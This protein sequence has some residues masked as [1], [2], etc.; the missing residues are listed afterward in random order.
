M[1]DALIFDTECYENFWYLGVKRCSDGKRVGYEFSDRADFDRSKVRRMLSRYL[2]VGFNSR[3]Y[4]LPMIYMA[5]DGAS[6]SELKAASNE[7]IGKSIPWWESER[8]FGIHI[9]KIDHIDLFDTNPSVKRGLKEINGSMHL[10]RLQELPY[11]HDTILSPEQMDEV[12]AYCQ[13]G[14]LDGT[15]KLYEIL[16]EPIDLRIAMGERYGDDYRSKSDAQMGEAIIKSEVEKKTNRRVR[17]GDV[18]IGASFRFEPPPWMKFETPQLQAVFNTVCTTDLTIDKNGKVRPPKEFKEVNTSFGASTYSI[19]IGGIHSTESNRSV[20]ADDNYVLIDADV[21]SQYPSIIMSRGLFPAALG[22]EFLPVYKA[23]LDQRLAAKKSGDKITDKG[24]K[25]SIN[26]AYGKLGSGYSVL[27]APQLLT[28]V[29]ITGQLSIL[30]LIERAEQA[31]VSVVSGNT[32]GVVFACP[33][34]MFNGL[35]GDALLPSKLKEITDWWMQ[36]TGFKLEFAQYTALYNESVNTYMAMTP[37]GKPKRKGYLAN[38]WNPKSPDYDMVRSGLMKTPQ[39]T[40]CS[41]AVL[42][43]LQHGTSIEDYIRECNDVREFVTIIKTAGGSTWRDE[44]LGKVVR[45]YWSTDGDPIYK[46]KAH[47]KTGNRPKVPNTEGCRHIM[48]MPEDF[49][50]PADLDFD[51][52]IERAHTILRN[53]GY[54]NRQI[55]GASIWESTLKRA[56]QFN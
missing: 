55:I 24:L 47:E 7:I 42:A 2:M 29:T 12:I 9:P 20:H 45:F 13:Y 31:G 44:Y 32:D 28:T 48:R 17:K 18:D 16:R 6:T 11:P 33:R 25:I 27:Y 52:Y 8:H 19:G 36:T 56:L 54:Y 51:R 39:M 37:S 14:D 40:V 35:D 49:S 41:D 22:K 3:S 43:F 30:M 34:S 23:L 21:A 4:D 15:Q 38:H 10:P 5:L 46:V 1:S 26:G 53:I 50:L